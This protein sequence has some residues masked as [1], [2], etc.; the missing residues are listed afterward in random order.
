MNR[1]STRIVCPLLDTRVQ[2]G[3]CE[4]TWICSGGHDRQDAG[5]QIRTV[6]LP[7]KWNAVGAQTVCQHGPI[8]KIKSDGNAT[9]SR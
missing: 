7:A 4:M 3:E 1:L 9:L 5:A 8:A 2:R 6:R